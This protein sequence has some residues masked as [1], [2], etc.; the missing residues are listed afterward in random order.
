MQ[1]VRTMRSQPICGASRVD[2]AISFDLTGKAALVTGANTGI[3]QAIA[4]ALSEAGA[5]VAVAGR[6]EPSETLAAIAATGRKAL[7]IKADLGST[8]PV[9]RLVDEDCDGSIF[10][11]IM[12][13]SSAA[14]I[15]SISARQIG[16]R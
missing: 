2:M 4:L 3:G 6:S 11:S 14:T 1:I 5:D 13:G 7:N 12:P 15:C 16:M 10:S 9:Q 8:E